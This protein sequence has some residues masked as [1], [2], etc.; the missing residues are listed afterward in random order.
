MAL[1]PKGTFCCCAVPALWTLPFLIRRIRSMEKKQ[2]TLADLAGL[3]VW[4]NAFNE[5]QLKNCSWI[6][7]KTSEI[8]WKQHKDITSV[9]PSTPCPSVQRGTGVTAGTKRGVEPALGTDGHWAVLGSVPAT[10]AAQCTC[11]S[12]PAARPMKQRCTGFCFG[13]FFVFPLGK[14]PEVRVCDTWLV[15]TSGQVQ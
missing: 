9:L 5:E 2:R 11:R 6:T 8:G 10:G 13:S 7:E 4:R 1:L 12:C 14:W 15:V 3:T